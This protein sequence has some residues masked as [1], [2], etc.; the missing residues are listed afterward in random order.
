VEWT[1]KYRPR[2]LGDVVGNNKAVQSL[3]SWARSWDS[4]KLPKKRAVILAGSPGVGKTSAAHALASDMGWG[5]IELNAS[6]TR[7]ADAIK[8]VA[9]AGALNQT[10]TDTGEFLTSDAGGRKLI[11]LDEADNMH[12]NADR[13]GVRAIL[14]TIRMT[15]QP[16]T[17]IVNDLYNLTRHSSTFKTQCLT[18]KFSSISARSI[19]PV[20]RRIAVAEHVDVEDATLETIAQRTSGDL[21]SAINDLQALS[22]GRSYVGTEDVDAVGKRDNRVTM[23]EAIRT[24]LK[25]DNIRSAKKAANELNEDPEFLLLWLS[26]NV[27]LEYKELDDLA[28]G[29][30][31]VA[32]AD[33]FLQRARRTGNYRMWAYAIDMMTGGVAT[34]KNKE[35]RFYNQYRF[36]MWLATMGRTKG[37]RATQNSLSH[38]LTT[39]CH[40]SATIARA[41]LI[42]FYRQM[43]DLDGAFAVEQTAQLELNASEL[44]MLIDDERDGKRVQVL[45]EAAEARVVSGHIDPGGL[46]LAAFA[47]K[48][49]VEVNEEEAEGTGEDGNG[50]DNGD[51]GGD[52][53]DVQRSL[54]EF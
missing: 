46:G 8:R 38:K 17:L 3:L 31:A 51:D 25:T 33:L 6:D 21:R 10:F 12:G 19:K 16:I 5:V 36:P 18:I 7:N 13:G 26:E 40:T 11:I 39:H 34:A 41:E 44:A 27:P 9:T 23:Y 30:E 54:F 49:V 2:T 53:P 29:M 20:L 24:I 4:S 22:E 28:R 1:E 14:E 42:P 50:K 15:R 43:F 47:D 48:E 35:Y 32:R 45:M 52:G 37:I